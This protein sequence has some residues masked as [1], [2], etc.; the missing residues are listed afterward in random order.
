MSNSNDS[1]NGLNCSG[2][3]LFLSRDFERPLVGLAGCSD[4]ISNDDK[5]LFKKKKKLRFKFYKINN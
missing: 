3:K 2:P 5:S 1:G 4:S